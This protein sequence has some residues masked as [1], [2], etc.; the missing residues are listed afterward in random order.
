MFH[1]R[2]LQ[3]NAHRTRHVARGIPD[4]PRSRALPQ[5]PTPPANPKPPTMR[6]RDAARYGWW[7]LHVGCKFAGRWVVAGDRDVEGTAS[8]GCQRTFA[9]SPE[10]FCLLDGLYRTPSASL[11]S[12][13]P[14]GRE[15]R[16]GA[17]LPGV[18]CRGCCFLREA[19]PY[20]RRV[21]FCRFSCPR[22]QKICIFFKKFPLFPLQL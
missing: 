10:G 11:P 18:G 4:A 15:P 13:A 22:T 17:G 14:S 20:L 12:A 2:G 9:N 7:I 1:N 5:P 16:V 21:W 19:L 6:V 3:I 8:Y